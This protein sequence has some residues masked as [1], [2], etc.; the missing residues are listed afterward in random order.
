MGKVSIDAKEIA[1]HALWKNLFANYAEAYSKALDKSEL[2][3]ESFKNKISHVNYTTVRYEEISQPNWKRITIKSNLP[4]NLEKLEEL[5]NNLWWSWN[6]EAR[7]LF[8][9]IGG[10][11]RW[12]E[13]MA[14][15][16]ML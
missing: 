5:A 9:E 2:R 11:E 4:S 14:K 3:F 7:E 15:S 12:N 13:I 8:I 16:D 1:A 6:Y 10:K